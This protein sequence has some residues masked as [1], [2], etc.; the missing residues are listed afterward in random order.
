MYY[1]IDQDEWG[2]IGRMGSTNMTVGERTILEGGSGI[3]A[4]IGWNPGPDEGLILRFLGGD[5][6]R[7]LDLSCFLLDADSRVIDRVWYEHPRSADGAILHTGNDHERREQGDDEDLIIDLAR[8]DDRARRIVFGITSFTRQPF[9]Q[10]EN[11][12][13][14][15]VDANGRNV[16]HLDLSEHPDE[17]GLIVGQLEREN[18]NWVF[19]SLRQDAD[20]AW[21]PPD[22]E[23]VIED[24]RP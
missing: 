5:Q 7:D 6:Q 22:L 13:F 20:L 14:R 21:T 10:I 3:Q 4:G 1:G 23:S 18:G 11:G 9:G 17:R 24:S 16:A 2:R 8:V 12:F 19:T 15:L